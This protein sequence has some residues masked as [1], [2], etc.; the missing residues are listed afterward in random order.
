MAAFLN[1]NGGNLFIG[2]SDDNT[3]EGLDEDLEFFSGSIDRMQLNISEVMMNAIGAD[4]KPYYTAQIREIQGKQI[5]HINVKPCLTSKTWVSF[6]VLNNFLLEMEMGQKVLL[7]K[8]LIAIGLSGH[9]C[10]FHPANGL[11]CGRIKN[12]EKV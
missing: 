2:V 4:K 6:G 1:T 5:C 10:N 7:V 3:I 12:L 8:M 11:S 9:H